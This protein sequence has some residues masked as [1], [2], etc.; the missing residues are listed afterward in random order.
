MVFYGK[1]TTYKIVHINLGLDSLKERRRR[2]KLIWVFAKT[3]IADGYFRGLTEPTQRGSETCPLILL[4]CRDGSIK[5]I[6]R[7]NGQQS[8]L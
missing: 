7:T 6:R 3:S 5:A 2:K 1:Y 8:L 4:Q